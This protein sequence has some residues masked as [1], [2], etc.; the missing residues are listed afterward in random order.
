MIEGF[1]NATPGVK[2]TIDTVVGQMKAAGA[3]VDVIN[4]PEHEIC[5]SNNI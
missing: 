3:I 5:T 2:S 4:I 1:R